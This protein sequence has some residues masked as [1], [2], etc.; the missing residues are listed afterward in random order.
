[1]ANG[2]DLLPAPK[3]EHL[4]AP[5]VAPRA[6]A[7]ALWGMAKGAYGLMKV[8]GQVYSGE[9]TPTTLSPAEASLE[10]GGGHLL[11]IPDYAKQLGMAG[12][13]IGPI[14]GGAPAGALET[15]P[16]WHGTGMSA[17][18]ERFENEYLGSGE[19]TQI[20]SLI[21]EH[22][23]GHYISGIPHEAKGYQQSVGR[24][25][26]GGGSFLSINVKP[27]QHEL[28]DW[29]KP[30]SQQ[31]EQVQDRL[32]NSNIGSVLK[33][34][35][36]T[37]RRGT[38]ADLYRAVMNKSYGDYERVARAAGTD[39]YIDTLSLKKMASQHLD[40]VGIPGMK[41]QAGGYG[42]KEG[43]DT[44]MYT[45]EDHAG[46][47]ETLSNYLYDNPDYFHGEFVAPAKGD[48]GNAVD[49][50]ISD[51]DDKLN[52]AKV[53]KE[54]GEF[55]SD[56]YR[57]DDY[58]YA[59]NWLDKNRDQFN[60]FSGVTPNNYVIFDGRH[61][62]ITHWNG[63]P[64]HPGST[65]TATH[66]L[67]PVEHDPFAEPPE[68]TLESTQ[69]PAP[70]P[71]PAMPV[72]P[73]VP[74]GSPPPPAQ[75]PVTYGTLKANYPNL[76]N[77]AELYGGSGK[78]AWDSLWSHAAG[79]PAMQAEMGKIFNDTTGHYDA[80]AQMMNKNPEDLPIHLQ[81]PPGN[82]PVEPSLLASPKPDFLVGG[83]GGAWE[84]EPMYPYQ[85]I[86]KQIDQPY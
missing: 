69:P 67:A 80:W 40:S 8:P 46:F 1:M 14:V 13:G 55:Q 86:Q 36:S 49:R 12:L 10:P 30:F 33:D 54:E 76:T 47:P 48:A 22:A 24:Y 37:L 68:G 63:D 75:A 79:N 45:G 38:G 9:L 61:I 71:S 16:A 50:I 51:M 19:G 42:V 72:E 18:F 5:D 32:L 35:D 62:E 4:L 81:P 27:D 44:L 39:P 56:G 65:A 2:N 66:T 84:P 29:D 70:I 28:L 21:G 31:S 25:R 60:I 26:E 43:Q 11:S 57:P 3:P 73:E 83:A 52:Q 58:Q 6:V 77:T 53:E 7:S 23:W 41:Y 34:P 82:V 20:P 64:L 74:W 78:L 15:F 85:D 17:P 59:I